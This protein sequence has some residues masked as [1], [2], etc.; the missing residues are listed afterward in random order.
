[1]E[2]QKVTADAGGA[3]GFKLTA[4]SCGKCVSCMCPMQAHAPAG[5]TVK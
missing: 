5:L 4:H 2:E 1:M 3:F